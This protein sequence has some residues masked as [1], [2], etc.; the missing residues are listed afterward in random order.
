MRDSRRFSRY[1]IFTKGVVFFLMGAL[2]ALT[3]SKVT[4]QLKGGSDILEWISTLSFGWFLLLLITI[5]L[6]GYVF[7]RFYLAFNDHDYVGHGKPKFRRFAYFVNGIGYL[8]L[9]FT[10]IKLLI[11]AG[12]SEDNQVFFVYL[13]STWWGKTLLIIA[14]ASLGISAL[15][16]WYMAFGKM[17]NKMILQDDLNIHQYGALLL[18]GRVGRF[19]R[20]IVFGVFSYLFF[21]VIIGWRSEV[22]RSTGEAFTFLSLEYGSWTMGVVAGGLAIYGLYLILSA[23]HRNIPIY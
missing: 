6:A 4:S 7:S 18:L 9:L 1:G 23:K 12:F 3:A 10:C 11:G 5:G 14:S 13:L 17:I 2:A 8:A 22:P 15:N 20:G 19:S 21:K 16:E